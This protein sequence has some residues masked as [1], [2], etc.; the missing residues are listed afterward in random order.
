MKKLFL[1]FMVTMGF[2]GFACRTAVTTVGPADPGPKANPKP[3]SQEELEVIS[4]ITEELA[5][6]PYLD[7][8]HHQNNVLCEDCHGT[9]K[10]GWDDPAEPDQCLSCHESRNALAVRFDQELARKWGNPHQSHL[11]DLDCGV[12]HKAHEPSTVYCLGCHTNAPFT[13]PG[14]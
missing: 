6:S 4:Q 3:L 11:G 7:G 12:C 8:L 9:A 2:I 14:Q 10:P 13:I 1:L 5:A